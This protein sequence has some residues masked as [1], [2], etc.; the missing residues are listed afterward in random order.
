LERMNPL[1]AERSRWRFHCGHERYVRRPQTARRLTR[2][3][4]R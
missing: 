4:I 1:V 3:T 2:M